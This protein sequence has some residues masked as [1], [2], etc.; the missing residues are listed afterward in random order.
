MAYAQ[1]TGSSTEIPK[2]S[3]DNT[4]KHTLTKLMQDSFTRFETILSKQAERMTTQELLTAI[5][6]KLVK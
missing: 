6:S 3:A 1:A 4:Q 2:I 5:L